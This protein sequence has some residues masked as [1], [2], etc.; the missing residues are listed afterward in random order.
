MASENRTSFYIDILAKMAGG[1]DAIASVTTLGDK[2]LAGKATVEEFEHTIKSMSGALE[3]STSAAKLSAD[4]LAEGEAKYKQAEIAADRAAKAVEKLNASGRS[5]DAFAKKQAEAVDKAEKAATA[6]RAEAAAVDALR[7]K[8]SAAAAQQDALSKGLKNVEAAAKQAAKAEGEAAGTGSLRSLASG[9][10][11]IGGPA[12]EAGRQVFGLANAFK[13]V[14]SSIGS[15]GPY[16]AIG[17]AIVAIAAAG[18]IAAAAITKLGVS[19]ADANRTQSLLA[20]GVAQSVEGGAELDKTIDKLGGVVPQTREELL[21]M[22]GDLAKTGLRGKD[23]S[24]ALEVAAVKAAKLKFGPDF[25]KEM[26]AL[27]VQSKRLGT[28]LAKTFGGLNIEKLL[29]GISTLVALFDSTTESGKALKFLFESLFQPIVDGAAGAIPMVERL[30]LKAEILALKAYIALKPYSSQISELGSMFLTGAEVIGGVFA[31]AIGAV[32]GSIALLVVEIG[33]IA[34]AIGK[35]VGWIYEFDKSVV[36]AFSA[37]DKWLTDIGT[38]MIE[39]LVDGISGGADAVVNAITGVADSAIA[40][41]KKALGIASRS[42]VLYGIGGFTAQGF[43]EGI[44]ENAGDA[45]SALENMVAPPAAAGGGGAGGGMSLSIG[46]LHLHGAGG[47]EMGDDFIERITRW[48][49]G[50]ASALGGGE[51]PSNA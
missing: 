37:A 20:A 8:S 1:D 28:N 30:F 32:I 23:L 19:Y 48:L 39:G 25:A 38:R 46:E 26:L 29:E 11:K 10:G 33:A 17:V 13:K 35:V 50:D 16:V 40:A 18:I 21:A 4:A 15:A 47:K 3:Q 24:N 5:G 7:G 22:A 49:E 31:Y 41:A 6:L 43:T 51:V 27:D 14:S 12:G 36:E 42:K 44:Q 45:Q 2:M 9:L 34:Y